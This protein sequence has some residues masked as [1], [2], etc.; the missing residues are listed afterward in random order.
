MSDS[1]FVLEQYDSTKT[2][3]QQKKFDCGHGVI[4]KFVR[5]SLKKQVSQQFSKAYV[6]LDCDDNERFCAF[7]TLT[8]FKLLASDMEKLSGGSLPKDIPCVRLVM[9]GVDNSLQGQGIGRKMMSDAL[10]R[11]HGASKV[12]G[13]YGLYL[14]ADPG[15]T[16]FY[17]SLGFT[18]LDDGSQDDIAKM[19]L[20]IE[21]IN[22]ILG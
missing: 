17:L 10:H 19:F 6:L 1:R 9:L 20:S 5:S 16:D 7:Y 11:V 22:G 14:D 12:I 2:Y 21:T 8:S 18:R 15:A 13:I 4:N 3:Y